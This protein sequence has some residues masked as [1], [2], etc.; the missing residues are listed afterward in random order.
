MNSNAIQDLLSL[1]KGVHGL[2]EIEYF[3]EIT[4]YP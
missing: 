1:M 3:N 4:P 2:V